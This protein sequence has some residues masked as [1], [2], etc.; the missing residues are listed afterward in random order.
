MSV[1]RT[2]LGP[3]DDQLQMLI[4]AGR[5]HDL[6]RLRFLRYC[7]QRDV[8]L[9]R[10]DLDSVVHGAPSGRLTDGLAKAA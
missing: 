2:P 6:N 9:G 5:P 10:E 7:A 8:Q 1:I 3:Y 4:D